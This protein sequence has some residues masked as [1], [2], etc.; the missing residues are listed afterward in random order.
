ME[1]PYYSPWADRGLVPFSPSVTNKLRLVTV[2]RS[3][4][5]MFNVLFRPTQ[6]GHPF[7]GILAISN[8]DRL[9]HN[10][11]SKCGLLTDLVG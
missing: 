7:V 2:C 3:P 6:P 11:D 8:G 9:G 4:N 5:F 10:W 1:V